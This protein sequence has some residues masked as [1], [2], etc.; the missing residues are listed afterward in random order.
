MKKALLMVF[1]L[2]ILISC[3]SEEEF[4]NIGITEPNADAVRTSSTIILTNKNELP[5]IEPIIDLFFP[6]EQSTYQ[7][8]FISFLKDN[9]NNNYT[10][11]TP[12]ESENCLLDEQ[13]DISNVVYFI[14]SSYRET[15]NCEGEGCKIGTVCTLVD[16]AQ[17]LLYSAQWR[18]ESTVPKNLP[19]YC[20]IGNSEGNTLYD[21]T[22]NLAGQNHELTQTSIFQSLSNE[23]S[24]GVGICF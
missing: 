5:R 10:R 22:E 3:K 23:T 11:V 24:S 1:I 6:I 13:C 21:C 9:E 8:R 16:D 20:L 4:N 18:S 14:W 12:I 17:T 2:T 7:I 15:E 19:E